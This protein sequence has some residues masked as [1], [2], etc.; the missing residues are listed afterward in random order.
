[1]MSDEEKEVEQKVIEKI[2]EQRAL[3]L[4]KSQ[5]QDEYYLK[6]LNTHMKVDVLYL[7]YRD[8]LVILGRNPELRLTEY[9][10][11]LNLI[12]G[13]SP[14]NNSNHMIKMFCLKFALTSFWYD[15]RFTD[16]ILCT[17]SSHFEL[18]RRHIV[19]ATMQP[20]AIIKSFYIFKYTFPSLL[21][22]IKFMMVY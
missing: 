4:P 19:Y 11:L 1:M 18:L 6:Y 12:K 9:N 5:E 7:F 2:K 14:E 16:S 3:C 10:N 17:L 8:I 21:P 22:S 13:M 20:F 15:P